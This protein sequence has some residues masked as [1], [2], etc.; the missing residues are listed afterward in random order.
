VRQQAPNPAPGRP[1]AKKRLI[2]PI[3][4]KNDALKLDYSAFQESSAILPLR[5]FHFL[6]L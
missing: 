4:A 3:N 5:I 2:W 6:Y 1:K